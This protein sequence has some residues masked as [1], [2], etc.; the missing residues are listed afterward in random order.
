MK[1]Q[2]RFEGTLKTWNHDRGFGFIEPAQG[3]QEVFVHITAFRE[4]RGRPQVAQHLSFELELA[5]NGKKRAK[6]V[7]A[8]RQRVARRKSRNDSPAQWGT[9]TLFA[10]PAF[11]VLFLGVAIVW[12]PPF[13]AALVYLVA[14]LVTFGVYMGDKE[15]ARGGVWR[16][17]EDTLHVLALAG[18][19]PGALIAQQFLRH[20][21]TKPEFRR[22]FWVTV[23]INVLAFVAVCSPWARAMWPVA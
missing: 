5:P 18:G 22:V 21:S 17:R 23:V 6:N 11:L 1:V 16:V 19:W 14:S 7:E 4:R 2:M 3:G 10:I 15:A 9:A 12:K 8:V 13:V 20:K